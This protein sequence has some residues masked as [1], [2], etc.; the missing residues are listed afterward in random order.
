MQ[1]VCQRQEPLSGVISEH[2]PPQ[3]EL[4]AREQYAKSP[5]EGISSINVTEAA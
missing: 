5:F 3:R 2:P 1:W 4:S